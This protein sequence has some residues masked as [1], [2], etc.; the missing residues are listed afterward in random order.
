MS[1]IRLGDCKFPD[2]LRVG[3]VC[4]SWNNLKIIRLSNIVRLKDHN[5]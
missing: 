4:A 5:E 3:S 1:L 2:Y